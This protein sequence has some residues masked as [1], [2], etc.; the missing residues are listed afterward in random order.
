VTVVWSPRAIGHL[1]E[2]RAYIARENFYADD[3]HLTAVFGA[4][5]PFMTHG[6]FA[7]A[8]LASRTGRCTLSRYV[9]PSKSS[10]I[11]KTLALSKPSTGSGSHW[12]EGL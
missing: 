2:L 8:Q 4:V 6:S 12:C 11:S 9:S 7:Q 1:A 3:A 10:T 5:A